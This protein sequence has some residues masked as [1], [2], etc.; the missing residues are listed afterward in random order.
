VEIPGQELERAAAD[1]TRDASR[2]LLRGLEA[3][4]GARFAVWIAKNQAQ[5]EVARKAIE[6]R[7]AIE[8]RR[9]VTKERRRFELEEIH[10]Q[11]QKALAQRRLERL[12]IE[13]AREQANVEAIATRS[14]K[15]IEQDEAGDKPREADVDWMFKFMRHAQDVSD[16]EMQEIWA[17]ILASSVIEGRQRLSPAAL[18]T[19]SLLDKRSAVDF[20]NFCRVVRSFHR[21]PVHPLI[22]KYETQGINLEN[23][24]ELGLIIG[25]DT[26]FLPRYRFEEF[27]MT[28]PGSMAMLHFRRLSQRGAQIE[29]AIFQQTDMRLGDDLEMKYWKDLVTAYVETEDPIDIIPKLEGKEAPYR[30]QIRKRAAEQQPSVD[31]DRQWYGLLPDRLRQIIEWAGGQYLVTTQ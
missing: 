16:A 26:R 22:H 23:L 28:Q 9:A 14:L 20:E 10:H 17:R 24:E 5:A 13:M 6:M 15:L 27:D 19:V 18:Q 3:V 29:R 31:L 4:L 30:I 11:E 7:G 21:Y 8:R 2:S 25:D 1:V 12:L